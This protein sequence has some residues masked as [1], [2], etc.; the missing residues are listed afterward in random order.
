MKNSLRHRYL[1]W[2]FL[3]IVL[4]L[5]PLLKNNFVDT[6]LILTF[7]WAIAS[8]GWGIS[9][10]AGLIGFG[11]AAAF[12]LGGLFSM[13]LFA[14][15]GLSP[16]I[17]MVV[18]ALIGMGLLTAFGAATVRM[19]AVKFGFA[20]L[21]LPLLLNVIV[22]YLGYREIPTP[23]GSSALNF[24]FTSNIQYYLIS[25][26]MMFGAI[27]FSKIVQNSKTGL[28]FRA[29]RDDE[30]A[31]KASGIDTMRYKL[32]ALALG[33]FVS[34]I[35]GTLYIQYVAIF[36]PESAFGFNTI[37]QIVIIPVIGGVG[38]VWGPIIGSFLLVPLGQSIQYFVGSS[39][40][41]GYL[42]VY[43][44]ILVIVVIFIPE[45]IY[46]RIREIRSSP[47]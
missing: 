39:W 32:I 23:P 43:G 41:G 7:I 11:H 38:T 47:K 16:W 27:L 24:Q 37:T 14:D 25:I 40:P 26:L 22:T 5:F 35:A 34:G 45:G 33:S 36:T 10:T 30:D 28:Y 15:Y 20:T 2:N 4:F 17:G 21:T 3:F 9:A 1:Y 31:A 44:V 6:A 8:V 13:I 42:I 12:G 19:S 18:G 29:I 46:S